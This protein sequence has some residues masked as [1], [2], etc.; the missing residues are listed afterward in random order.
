MKRIPMPLVTALAAALSLSACAQLGIGQKKSVEAP[1]ASLP[2][3]QAAQAAAPTV[4]PVVTTA[5]PPSRAAN[6]QATLDTTTPE[7]RKKAAAPVAPQTGTKSLGSTVASLGSPTEPGFWLKTPLVKSETMGRVTNK[8]NGKSSA[9][10]LIP[11]DGPATGGSRLSL[12]AM[13]LIE[14]SLTELTELTVTSDG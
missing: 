5:P 1:A 6:T 10:R 7:Q 3:G 11:I 13:R 2:E 9:V 14:A 4:D 8:A 12:P